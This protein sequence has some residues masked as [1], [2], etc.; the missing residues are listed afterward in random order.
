MARRAD[1][2]YRLHPSLAA[3][4]H[5]LLHHARRR[6]RALRPTA[7][8]RFEFARGNVGTDELG[9]TRFD[10]WV[11]YVKNEERKR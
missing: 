3:V 6:V 10:L 5:H 4:D 1:G 2:A 8:G 7:E 9:T 11:R